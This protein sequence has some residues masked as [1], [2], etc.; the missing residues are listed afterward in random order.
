VLSLST[1]DPEPD[2]DTLSSGS[3]SKTLVLGVHLL[4]LDKL[5]WYAWGDMIEN[6][7]FSFFKMREGFESSCNSLHCNGTLQYSVQ[8]GTWLLNCRLCSLNRFLAP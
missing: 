8:Y 3:R 4:Q 5:L 6:N 1:L 2:P 7:L